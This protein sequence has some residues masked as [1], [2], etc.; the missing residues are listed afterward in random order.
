MSTNLGK[1]PNK[2]RRFWLEPAKRGGSIKPGVER[3]RTP[4]SWEDKG[5]ARGARRQSF[6]INRPYVLG[7]RTLR[8][9]YFFGRQPGV[10]LCFTQALCLHALTRVSENPISC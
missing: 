1:S 4:G 6:I 5:R 8:A 9:L 2:Y 7:Y 3:S 10:P